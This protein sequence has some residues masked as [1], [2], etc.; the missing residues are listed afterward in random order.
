MSA[1]ISHDPWSTLDDLLGVE[2]AEAATET[3]G[4]VA[5][6]GRCGYVVEDRV[7]MGKR[8]VDRSGDPTSR[9]DAVTTEFLPDRKR[10]DEGDSDE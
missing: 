5:F 4:S 6:Y 9:T 3:V 8:F 2:V 1:E 10:I 7:S